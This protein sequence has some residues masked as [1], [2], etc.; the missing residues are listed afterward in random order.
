MRI[1]ARKTADRRDA[2]S[3]SGPASGGWPTLWCFDLPF[4]FRTEGA[5]SLCFVGGTMLPKLLAWLVLGPSIKTIHCW[6]SGTR[7]SQRARRTGPPTAVVASAIQR[8]GHRPK[9]AGAGHP[10]LQNG[11]GKR[12]RKLGPPALRGILR[13]WMCMRRRRTARPRPAIHSPWRKNSGCRILC[14]RPPWNGAGQLCP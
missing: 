4:S 13:S 14:M 10:Q 2:P 9:N 12:D 11:N 3:L 6:Q 1:A 8:L 7:P 5:P